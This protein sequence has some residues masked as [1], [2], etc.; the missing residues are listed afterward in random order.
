[1]SYFKNANV[2]L[3]VF[4]GTTFPRVWQKKM[5]I[6]FLRFRNTANFFS[7]YEKIGILETVK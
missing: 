4:R 6:L 5:N 1:M 7:S 3:S 2:F